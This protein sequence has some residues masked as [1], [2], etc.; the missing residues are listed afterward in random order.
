MVENGSIPSPGMNIVSKAGALLNALAAAGES[1]PAELSA[2][3]GEPTSSVYRLIANL[4][5]IGWV[6]RG[7]A[8]GRV[9]L[10]LAFLK[11]G[12]SLERQLDIRRIALPELQGLS[13]STQ[14]AAFLCIRRGWTA[15]CI[16]R[17][18]G[19]QVISRALSLGASLPLH[20][21]AASRAILAFESSEFIESFFAAAAGQRDPLL[22]DVDARTLRHQLLETV[23][24]GTSFS[25]S[26]VNPGIA[27]I[28]APVF[29]HRGEVVAALAV[30]GIRSR[31]V[32]TAD[33]LAQSAQLAAVSVSEALGYVRPARP[34][35][36]L[37]GKQQ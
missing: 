6:E 27:S 18:D 36:V 1:T 20:R 8:R 28:G 35:E 34:S 9:K 3:L 30:S 33:H 16:E 15:V 23:E 21:S 25:D 26:D 5:S 17:I 10:G 12:R 29:N 7:T 2:S 11:S 31:I 37:D 4:E 14:Q 24:A 13:A 22:V 19:T 32:E